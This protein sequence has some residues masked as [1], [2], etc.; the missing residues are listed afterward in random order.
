MDALLLRAASLITNGLCEF[1]LLDAIGVTETNALS[2]VEG[3]SISNSA[4]GGSY[5]HV[6]IGGIEESTLRDSEESN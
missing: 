6:S 2:A 1:L 3:V 5:W 4:I